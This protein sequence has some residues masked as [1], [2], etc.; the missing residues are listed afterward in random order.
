MSSLQV[1]VIHRRKAEAHRLFNGRAILRGGGLEPAVHLLQEQ[2]TQ[3][4]LSAARPEILRRACLVA[5]LQLEKAILKT[6]LQR[7]E[8]EVL[9]AL[10]GEDDA[11]DVLLCPQ[12]EQALNGVERC[13]IP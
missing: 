9:R 2:T 10:A 11:V 1:A 12:R 8:R 3:G 5:Q 4:V 6:A 13:G 7:G